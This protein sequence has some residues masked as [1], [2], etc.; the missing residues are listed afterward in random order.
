[1]VR[2]CLA[3]ALA[4]WFS[5]GSKATGVASRPAATSAPTFAAMPPT[6]VADLILNTV[7]RWAVKQDDDRT[8]LICDYVGVA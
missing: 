1:M 2:W 7:K 3:P 5:D 4:P 8:L 6:E